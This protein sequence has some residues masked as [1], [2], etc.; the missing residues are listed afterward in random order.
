MRQL[1]NINTAPLRLD[2][3]VPLG[4]YDITSPKAS[5]DVNIKK[6]EM[7]VKKDPVR[8]KIDRREMYD[9]MG[10]YMPDNFRRK[11]EGEAK[12]LVMDTIAEIGDDW[13]AVGESPG[14]TIIVDIAMK[15]SLDRYHGPVE[16]HSAWIPSVKPNITWDGGTPTK[17]DF[18]QFRMDINWSTHPRPNVQ[19]H[20][21]KKEINVAQWQKVNIEYVG[22]TSDIIKLGSENARK[23][24]IKI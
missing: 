20:M 11:T 9:S 24:N 13:R 1:L 12:Q 14:N 3:N 23:L 8:L 15:N 19:Y 2:I 7:T 4:R 18:S 10:I 21:G 17:V 22:T 6:A 5:W 16:L